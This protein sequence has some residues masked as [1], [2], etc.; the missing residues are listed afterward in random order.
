MLPNFLNSAEL[1]MPTWVHRERITNAVWDTLQNP[2]AAVQ[3][4][5]RKAVV[6]SAFPLSLMT[7]YSC[8]NVQQASPWL[9]GTPFTYEGFMVSCFDKGRLK[10]AEREMAGYVKEGRLHIREDVLQGSIEDAPTAFI[11]ML[12]GK[13]RGKQLLELRDA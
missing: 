8:Q 1:K 11:R 7:A 12:S 5:A 9:A 4:V 3:A 6:H 13:N 2:W 10:R